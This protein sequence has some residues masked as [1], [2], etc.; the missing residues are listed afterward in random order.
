MPLVQELFD[1]A[2]KHLYSHLVR[3]FG[4]LEPVPHNHN[5]FLFVLANGGC[6]FHPNVRPLLD[7]RS[8]M[9]VAASIKEVSE[10]DLELQE[11][12]RVDSAVRLA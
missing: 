4:L 10:F 8:H 11:G 3:H 2:L 5:H 7:E 1:D 12:F 9:V 6:V